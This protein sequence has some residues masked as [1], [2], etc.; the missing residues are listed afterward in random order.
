M[1]V[2]HGYSVFRIVLDGVFSKDGDGVRFHP[3][4]SLDAAD[5]VDILTTFEAY[6]RPVLAQPKARAGA[7]PR[8]ERD[9][10]LHGRVA[11]TKLHP[12]PVSESSLL[13]GRVI[14]GPLLT[15]G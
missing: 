8:P 2:R 12:C 4:P 11:M 5:L 10:S 1:P 7:G 3:S 6:L 9:P 15:L 13:R 14:C